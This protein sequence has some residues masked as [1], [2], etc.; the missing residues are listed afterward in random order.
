MEDKDGEGCDVCPGCG[1]RFECGMR[2]GRQSCWCA[3]LPSVPIVA[4]KACFCPEC[5]ARRVAEA[6]RLSE[7]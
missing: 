4:A 1:R 5:L 6:A 7:K 2:A 3:A